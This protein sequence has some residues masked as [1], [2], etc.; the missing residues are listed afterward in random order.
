MVDFSS[1]LDAYEREAATRIGALAAHGA[2]R[3]MES[4]LDA[5]FA[6]RI[7]FGIPAE[8]AREQSLA[9]IGDLGSIAR[10][11]EPAW[12]AQLFLIPFFAAALWE[13]NSRVNVP[14]PVHH[15]IFLI[16]VAFTVFYSVRK[17][18]VRY[19]EIVSGGLLATVTL[20]ALVLLF[21]GRPMHFYLARD[22]GSGWALFSLP[23]LFVHL[24]AAACARDRRRRVRG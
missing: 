12:D 16:P 1:E 14:L 21:V 18:R 22:L 20:L 17:P 24:I 2:R 11:E 9:A 6:A 8:K 23:Y 15:L 3:E 5:D 4:H 13:L 7:E 10:R 19:L